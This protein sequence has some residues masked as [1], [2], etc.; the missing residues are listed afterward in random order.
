M[1]TETLERLKGSV[2]LV[3]VAHR[4]STLRVCDKVLVLR[5]GRTEAFASRADLER[6]NEYYNSAIQLAALS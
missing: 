3:V 2:T 1:I 6:D 4:L 5:D